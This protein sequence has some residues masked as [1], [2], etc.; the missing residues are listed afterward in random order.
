VPDTQHGFDFEETFARE[1]GLDPV[2]GSGNQWHSKLDETGFGA[3][4][5]LKSTQFKSYPVSQGEIDEVVM[6]CEGPGGAGEMPLWAFRI[7]DDEHVL[8]GIRPVDFKR[9]A[10]GELVL[11]RETKA[12]SRRR[13]ASIPILLRDEE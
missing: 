9:L 12:E 6:A 7:G 8:I 1:M 5:G 2:P 11:A 10:A 3:R 4:W 13:R